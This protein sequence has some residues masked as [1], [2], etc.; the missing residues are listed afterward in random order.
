M[1]ATRGHYENPPSEQFV[2]LMRTQEEEWLLS[3]PIITPLSPLDKPNP[4]HHLPS[5][6]F[7]DPPPQPPAPPTHSQTHGVEDVPGDKQGGPG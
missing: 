3:L 5:S 7:R 2:C 1:T 4:S 6:T